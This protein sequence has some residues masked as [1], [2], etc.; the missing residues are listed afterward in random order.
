MTK[1]SVFTDE[2]SQDF[3]E[4]VRTA[5]DAGLTFVDL[6]NA[7]NRSCA[8]LK[9]DD[10]QKL[11]EIMQR[12]GV[13]LG[14]IQS[15][16]GKCDLAEDDYQR[17]LAFLPNL[18]EQ[19]HFFGTDVIRIFPFWQSDHA[20]TKLR[21]NLA[22]LLE[23]IVTKLR[24]ATRLAEREG[25]YLALEPEHS[26]FGG[27]PTEIRTI[28]DAVDSPALR[29]SWDVSNGWLPDEPIFPDGYARVKGLVVNVHVKDRA[30]P[31]DEEDGRHAPTLLGA[32]LVP[33]PRVIQTLKAD[34]YDGVYTIETHFGSKTRYG[35]PKL[36]AATTYYMY[37][38]R[39]L[40]EDNA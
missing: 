32:G 17:H 16:F 15:P 8:E 14:A 31:P 34:G 30:F 9:R 10:W 13:R 2:I 12:H 7:W 22:P 25:V 6:R 26:T 38:L 37:A 11:A 28:V 21:P 1:A 19:A 20:N 39:E 35:W 23:E 27:S 36:K 3:E 4:A 24:R 5:A 40:L 33:W 29:V 18:I